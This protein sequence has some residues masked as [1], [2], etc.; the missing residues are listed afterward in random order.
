MKKIIKGNIFGNA[1]FL[2]G[3]LVIIGNYWVLK[4]VFF[5]QDEW[6]AFGDFFAIKDN[7]L[8]NLLLKAVEPSV[9]HYV[10]FYYGLFFTSISLFGLNDVWYAILSI[11]LH[12]TIASVVYLVSFKLFKDKIL[13]F[14]TMLLW[15]LNASG[16]Q[17]TSWLV[18]DLNTHGASIFGLLSVF[19]FFKF[20]QE[21]KKKLFYFSIISLIASLMFKEIAV[22]LFLL[23]PFAYLL[24][25]Q[26]N[27]SRKY[28]VILIIFLVGLLYVSVRVSMF[29][30]PNQEAPV[31]TES[32]T[33]EYL[34]YN[35]LSFPIKG[36]VQ[37]ILPPSVL[38]DTAHKITPNLRGVNL[39]EKGTMELD[40][41]TE[42]K[43]LEPIL[44][45]I[46]FVVVLTTFIIWWWN[47]NNQM[48]KV[49]IYG[50]VF[51][52]LNS[53]IFAFSP[54]RSG[55]IT[56]ID[57]RNLYF[58]S[59]GVVIFLIAL[60]SVITNGKRL[61]VFVLL[62]PI[63][64]LHV[65][66][67]N[68]ELQILKI[69]GTVR[70]NILT[71]IKGHYFKL[72][73]KVIFYT[74]SDK[75]F[76]GLSPNERIFP[77][78]SG[79]G[80][81]LLVWYQLTEQF[82]RD[83]FK[84][85]FLWDIKSQGYKQINNRGFGY[86]RNFEELAKTVKNNK[87][88]PSSVIAFQFDSEKQIT[89]DISEEVRG[90]L[91]GYLAEKREVTPQIITFSSTQNTKDLQNIND[92]NRETAWDSK[93]AYEQSQFITIEFPS[94]LVVAQIQIDSYNNKD[95]N[96]VGYK[97]S[98]SENGSDWEKVF[99]AKR[100]TPDSEGIVNI[101]IKPQQAKFVKIEQIGYHQFAPWVVYELKLYENK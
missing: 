59:I 50:L 17:A 85:R 58:A 76:Y 38:I 101:Y 9:G 32:Q 65:F 98:I 24:F 60:I 94:A 16:Q 93:L 56:V 75:S 86:F 45:A 18:A 92:G 100:Y 7:G 3:L 15:G 36:I 87:L 51:V 44:F 31:I 30:L 62:L 23:L 5:Q 27:Q 63:L 68:K 90:R 10:P 77:F 2:I 57:S 26:K 22:G 39:P 33:P 46:F 43:I 78:Q 4:D 97:V 95:Q 11:I 55:K 66:W 84:D 83:F 67:L 49:A 6:L 79:F 69:S 91:E 53:F 13:A 70:K 81:T 74:E 52:G 61:K 40:L 72:P 20:L 25:S 48:V 82:P 64:L 34:I 37:T 99:Y 14:F 19:Y 41:F 35:I 21:N 47:K 96:E 80:Q 54:E 1:L 88:D 28:I 71:N 42:E 29:L 73:E 8:I 12:I 89:S